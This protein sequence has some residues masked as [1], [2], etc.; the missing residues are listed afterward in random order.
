[1]ISNFFLFFS[2]TIKISLLD[3][4]KSIDLT[5]YDN[6]LT[7]FEEY[8]NNFLSSIPIGHIYGD[9]LYF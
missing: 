3:R 6:K 1:M 8:A 9:N 5:N 4:N 2:K 7:N